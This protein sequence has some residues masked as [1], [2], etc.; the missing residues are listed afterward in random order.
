VT[1][2]KS[3]PDELLTERSLT[4]FTFRE[5]SLSALRTYYN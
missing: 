4:D 5:R 2:N 3:V 1:Y